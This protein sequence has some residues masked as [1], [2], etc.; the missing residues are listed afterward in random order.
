[1]SDISSRI[2]ESATHCFIKYGYQ[3]TTLEDIGKAVGLKKTPFIT[4]LKIKKRLLS[5]LFK[6]NWELLQINIKPA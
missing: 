5:L 3:K 1:M 4:I 2:L 6:M